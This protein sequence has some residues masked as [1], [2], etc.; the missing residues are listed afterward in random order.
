MVTE[1]VFKNSDGSNTT[2]TNWHRSNTSN[3]FYNEPNDLGLADK[4]AEDC[5]A[6]N[7]EGEWFDE[8]CTKRYRALCYTKLRK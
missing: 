2:Y 4:P 8:T 7:K 3:T 6:I 1:G 5:V